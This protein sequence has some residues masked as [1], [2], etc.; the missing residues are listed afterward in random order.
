[1]SD[2]PQGPLPADCEESVFN[3]IRDV[4]VNV[5]TLTVLRKRLAAKYKIDFSPHDAAVEMAVQKYLSSPEGVRELAKVRMAKAEGPMGGKGKKRSRSQK[6]DGKESKK[7]KDDKAKKE[8]KPDNYP[9]AAL[10]AYIIFG[11]EQREKIKAE[12]PGIAITEILK[13]TGRRWAAASEEEKEHYKKL[14]EADKVRFDKELKVYLADGGRVYKRGQKDGKGS[15]GEAKGPKRAL[16]SYMYFANDFRVKHPELGMTEQMK[17]AGMEWKK[18][19][20]EEKKPFELKAAQDKERYQRECQEQGVKTKSNNASKA[21]AAED[22]PSS[23][24]ASSD[25]DS[26]SDE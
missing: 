12:N 8:K 19:T 9:K 25:S 22:T 11:N 3:I 10:S 6:E 20:D 14:A 2:F 24:D 5:L 23:S 17:Q 18:L 15:K 1:M 16:S 26:D 4:G 7:S 13:E 21:V